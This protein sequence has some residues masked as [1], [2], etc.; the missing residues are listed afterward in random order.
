MTQDELFLFARRQPFK[1]FRLT[2]S[3]GK[4]LEVRHPELIMVGRRS[5]GVGVA[6]RP[7]STMH[8]HLIQVDLVHIVTAEEVP[9]PS[10]PSN[11][12]DAMTA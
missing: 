4:V 11:G 10:T 3:T 7:G 5:A 6:S 2:L 9:E 12:T 8:D 1:P